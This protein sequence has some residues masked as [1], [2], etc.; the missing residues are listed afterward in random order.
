M[1]LTFQHPQLL[2]ELCSLTVQMGKGSS[3]SADWHSYAE[4]EAQS[5]WSLGI[6]D[7]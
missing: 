5:L 1:P 4:R 7:L 2:G 3:D 6:P